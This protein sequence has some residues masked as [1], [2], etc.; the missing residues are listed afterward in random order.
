MPMFQ[1]YMCCKKTVRKTQAGLFRMSECIGELMQS[2]RFAVRRIHAATLKRKREQSEGEFNLPDRK[3][4]TRRYIR[5]QR[6]PFVP[7]P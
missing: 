2:S 1:H 4:A 6:E 7:D 3:Q 5:P